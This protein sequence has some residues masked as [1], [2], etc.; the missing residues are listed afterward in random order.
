MTPE[1]ID[2]VRSSFAK[3]EALGDRVAVMFYDR[4]FELD[5]S[6]RSLFKGD[7]AVQRSKLL[8][9][10]A[11]VVRGLDRPDRILPAVRELGRRHARYGVEPDHYATVASALI[12]ALW[13][14]LGP[15]F[16]P[17]LRRAW[18]DAYSLLAWTM[19][20]AAEAE[21]RHKLAA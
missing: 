15:E 11:L 21:A 8:A 3:L 17:A 13:Q 20:A 4:L 5:P 19:I 2:L 10:L 9:A 6:L 1:Q 14:A 18:V 16:T 12:W 7:L